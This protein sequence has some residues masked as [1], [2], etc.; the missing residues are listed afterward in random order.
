M[1]F[2]EAF[3]G[4]SMG[5]KWV[6]SDSHALFCGCS[7]ILKLHVSLRK[8]ADRQGMRRRP[9]QRQL[10]HRDAA[11][12]R[13]KEEPKARTSRGTSYSQIRYRC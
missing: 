8:P 12:T 6:F 7:T 13:P 4:F 11:Q 9:S 2:F 1:D 5:L 3:G 10:V